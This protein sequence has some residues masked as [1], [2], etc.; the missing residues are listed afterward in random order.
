[1]RGLTE[2]SYLVALEYLE[3]DAKELI[4]QKL[5]DRLQTQYQQDYVVYDARSC[6]GSTTR[7][8]NPH[9]NIHIDIVP[10]GGLQEEFEGDQIN[11]H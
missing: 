10:V 4:L 9:E 1:M 11:D 7:M 2:I 8:I 5:R 3:E 6:G